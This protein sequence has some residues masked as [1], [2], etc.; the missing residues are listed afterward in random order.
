MSMRDY[1]Y[2]DYGL[3]LDE[4]IIND[5]AAQVCEDFTEITNEYWGYELYEKGI[6]EYA[7]DFT[8]E[9]I[10]IDDKGND[11][12]RTTMIYSGESL[13][14]IPLDK[15]PSLLNNAYNSIDE[16]I[17]ELKEKIGK[18]M[19]KDYNYRANIRHIVGTTF[20]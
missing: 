11:D 18:Y 19:P 16:I 3:V 15:Y 5:I 7:G 4:D 2:V 20:G 13:C 1:A 8:G 10:C 14:Y 9:A 12:W 17:D 6:C